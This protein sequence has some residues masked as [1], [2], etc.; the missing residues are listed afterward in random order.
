MNLK[1]YLWENFN[2]LQ[3]S[4]LLPSR[5]RTRILRLLGTKLHPSVRIMENVYLGSNKL[6]AGKTLSSTSVAFSTVQS[7]FT[8]VYRVEA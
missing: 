4:P 7:P 8:L 3:Q 6:V 5:I 1:E 2:A